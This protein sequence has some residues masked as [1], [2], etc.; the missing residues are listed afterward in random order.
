M[1]SE[2]LLKSLSAPLSKSVTEFT[3]TKFNHLWSVKNFPLVPT[4]PEFIQSSNFSPPNSKDKWFMKLRP[5]KIDEA[6]GIEYIAIHIFLRSCEDRN[7]QNQRAKYSISVL[8]IDG[9]RKFTAECGRPEGRIF[10]AGTEGHGF[11]M[12]VPR[13]ILLTPANNMLGPDDTLQILCELTVFGEM[14]NKLMPVYD[15]NLYCEYELTSLGTLTSDFAS[16]INSGIDCDIIVASRDGIEFNAHRLVLKARSKVFEAMFEHETKEKAENRVQ[17]P[18][19]DGPVIREM[20]KFIYSDSIDEVEINGVA[21]ELL[22]AADKYYLPRLKKLCEQYLAS[23]I[24]VETCGYLLSLSDMANCEKLKEKVLEFSAA[25]SIKLSETDSW[26]EDLS[27]RPYLYGEAYNAL[28]KKLK[29][30]SI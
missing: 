10:R 3:V 1:A 21:S 9:E 26:K 22:L 25:N 4:D 6:T 16:L 8:D 28:N 29:S 5:K 17:I 24:T 18:D 30:N 12:I 7:E 19:F 14:V 15:L 27:T 2:K 13:E 11:K 23:K 20:L